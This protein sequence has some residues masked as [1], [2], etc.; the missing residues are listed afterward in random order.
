MTAVRYALAALLLALG[1]SPA[2]AQEASR[3]NTGSLGAADACT[4][5]DSSG[6][7]TGVWQVTGTFEGTITF[8]V[9]ADGTNFVAIDVA[10]P[11]NPGTPVNTTTSTGLWSAAV[12]GTRRMKACMTA[13]TSGTAIVTTSAAATGG[14]GGGSSAT[15]TGDITVTDVG[16]TSI[17]AGDNN[18]GN[19]DVASS[20]LP[21]GASTSAKQDTIIGH[22]DGLEGLLAG[23]L[24]V[25][26]T[27]TANLSATDNAV[28]DDIADG[29]AVTNAGTFAVQSTNAA[30]TTKQIGTVRLADGAG[31]ALT[32]LSAGSERSITVAVVDGS[33]NQVSS[34]GG[35]GGTA[36]AFA[37]AFPSGASSGTAIGFTDG[38]NMQ[39]GRVVDADTGAGTF[40]AQ[41]VNN[42][43]RASGT[44]VE[45]GTSSNPWNVV[46]P[47]AQAVTVSGT[48]TVGSHA[49]TNAGTFAVQATL[50]AGATSIGKAE[51]VASADADVGVPAFAVRKATPANTSGTD[52]DYEALQ[53]SA[54]RL[55]TSSTIDAALPAGTNAIG[56]LA[57]NSGVTI[58]AVELAA[59]QTLAT[60]T[61]VGT[62]STVTTLS[63]LGGTAVPIEDA[64]ETA[65]GTGLYAM[66]VRR[67][68]A[69]SSAGTTGDNAT[70]NTDSLGRLWTTG[71]AVEDAAET[72]GGILV[73]GG[74][75]RRD[76]AASSAGTTGD[77]ATFNTDAVGA[78][79]VNPFSQTQAAGTYLTMRLSDGSSYLTPGSDYTHDAALTASTTAGPMQVGRGSDS[80]PTNVS[81]NDDAVLAWYLRNGSAV[82]NIAA[83]STLIT[84]TST[85]L[86][87]NCTGGCSGGAQY[88]EDAA[89][90]SGDSLTM[91][92][93]VRQDTK[94]TGIGANGDNANFYVNASGELYTTASGNVAHDAAASSV[95]PLL[96]GAYASAAAPSDV[97]AD[98]D[99]VRLWALRNGSQV[100]NLAAGGTLI[101]STGANLNVQ[102]ANCSGS[103]ASGVDDAA[104][105]IATDSVAPSGHLFDDVAPD[106]VNEGDVGLSRMSANRN[107]YVQIRDA[108][109]N[110][111]GLN[112][113]A[114][115][116]LAVT[117][118]A[119]QTLATVTTVGAVTAITNA[120]PAGT[121]AIGKLAANSGVDIGDVDVTTV[122]TITP[123]TAASSL[124]KAE[125]AAH[126]SGDTGVAVFGR[127]I[128]TLA[129]SSGASGDYE[130]FN[131]NGSGALWVSER[132]PCSS[133]AKQFIAINQATGTQL[134]T[135]TASNRTYICHISLVTATA[136]NVAL[137]S[138]TGTVCATSTGPLM[139]GTTAAT[140]WNFAANTGIAA[141][142]GGAS[143]AKSDTDADNVCLLQS[144]TGQ[145]SGVI[146]YVVAPN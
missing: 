67:D 123:G 137:V 38:T 15:I 47:S 73:M 49:V 138:G 52:G 19:V 72:A 93:T 24:T 103:G 118:A 129:A 76:T 68:T 132:D 53:M 111:R 3:V 139:G 117:L 106:S 23:T 78:L 59:S 116:Q 94:G 83:G 6:M 4:T 86:N 127:R 112:I 131:M 32:S 62:V 39:G 16:I 41:A 57:S 136:Q 81:A 21:T 55:W 54:G 87:V 58:G 128:D 2:F 35:S 144:S 40:Y 91:A 97:S 98:T 17:A 142:G 34:F 51:D 13:Y 46:F 80:A 79:W 125:D 43:F 66:S 70:I 90:S 115:G 141:G 130:T 64:A 105:V 89:H 135:G 63:Q 143:I 56:K 10:T 50:A 71:S 26:G 146:T 9:S 110:E 65:G 122:G 133:G 11:D 12:A 28:L 101:T 27:V 120:L 119:A 69:A 92:G 104:F 124:G 60:V 84:A 126:A 95:N 29:I 74:T 108:A 96:V 100:V 31:N 85:S 1:V 5:L 45:A 102:C 109:G 22:V 44:P 61:T 77:N 107:Q 20:A 7:G 113:D 36:S 82:T 88:A 134:F 37:A 121:N 99:S 14:G 30:E 48:V 33:G 42:V 114:S 145:I 75:V 140:G 8:Y 18:I 25:G